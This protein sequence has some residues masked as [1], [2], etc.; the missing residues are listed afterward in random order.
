MVQ[1]DGM[2]RKIVVIPLSDFN[3]LSHALGYKSESLQESQMLEVKAVQPSLVSSP[4]SGRSETEQPKS[5]SL[6]GTV[7]DVHKKL[8][9]AVISSYFA[10]ETNY[11]VV[12]D[13]RYFE[14]EGTSNNTYFAYDVPDQ[15]K[16]KLAGKQILEQID[17]YEYSYFSSQAYTINQVREGF[18]LLL[19]VGIF[20]SIVFFVATGSFLYFRLYTDLADDK[21]HYQAIAKI[22]LAMHELRKIAT[23]QVA[24]L[25][26]APFAVAVIHSAVAM[27]AL[28]SLFDKTVL[29]SALLV[30]GGFFAAQT[31]FFLL[32]RSRYVKHLAEAIR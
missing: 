24:L 5:L 16:S 11:Y 25:F 18:S 32:I 1:P 23:T 10:N 20:V 2:E 19:F 30:I 8:D 27:Y 15:R 22:G 14:L 13:D 3:Q 6:S 28:H 29:T 4:K 21:R 26:Y 12:S 31:L 7:F 9:R 17:S